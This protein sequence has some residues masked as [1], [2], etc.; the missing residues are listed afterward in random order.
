MIL[1]QWVV[2]TVHAHPQEET[3]PPAK[4][5][6]LGWIRICMAASVKIWMPKY[7][8]TIL[9][10]GQSFWP[11]S[12]WFDMVVKS[13]KFVGKM[14]RWISVDVWDVQLSQIHWT[15][16][17]SLMHQSTVDECK[18]DMSL[19]NTHAVTCRNPDKEVDLPAMV[20]YKVWQ[21]KYQARN[22]WRAWRKLQYINNF[23]ASLKEIELTKIIHLLHPSPVS[24][25]LWI[26]DS[27]KQTNLSCSY[28]I[29]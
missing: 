11:T 24:N 25:R 3:R 29:H 20:L 28:S 7:W 27:W 23:L 26:E 12:I 19:W 5:M 4:G 22:A 9:F 15:L 16:E 17:V 8:K 21:I 6:N 13:S 18:E 10:A 2:A 14:T 1:C